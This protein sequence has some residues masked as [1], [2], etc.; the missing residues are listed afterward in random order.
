MKYYR[1]TKSKKR[2]STKE[3]EEAVLIATEQLVKEK[4]FHNVGITEIMRVAAIQPHV[5]Y[6]HFNNIEDIYDKFLRRYDYWLHDIV[7]YKL[8][9]DNPVSS[10]KNTLIEL[11]K[12]LYADRIMQEILVWE[13][14][15][16]NQLTCRNAL[17]R[18]INSLSL[19]NFFRDN[20][21]TNVNISAL[22]SMLIGGIYYLILRRDRS[23]FCGIDF[24]SEKGKESLIK[25]I[26]D[27]LDNLFVIESEEDKIVK[28]AK[29]L[30]EAGVDE[31]TI[32]KSTM[33]SKQKMKELKQICNLK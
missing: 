9:E 29:K 17:N 30:F 11:I 19:L 32:L 13:V 25:F 4:G 12:S 26:N 16:K 10:A 8:D 21:P 7:E 27:I 3:I 33:I 1:S 20:L 22:M 31:E 23:S 2:R 6:R 14:F 15:D 5:M 28:I 18:E 24:D